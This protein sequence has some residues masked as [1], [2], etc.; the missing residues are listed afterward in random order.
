MA[1]AEVEPILN[2]AEYSETKAT[3]KRV[4]I[5]PAYSAIVAFSSQ[6]NKN[7]ENQK[8]QTLVSDVDE[9]KSLKLTGLGVNV[10]C[11]NSMGSYV[12]LRQPLRVNLC[13]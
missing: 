3:T 7:E 8:N 13:H 6:E 5:R 9:C 2:Q 1:A 4:W 10:N 12:S 11:L